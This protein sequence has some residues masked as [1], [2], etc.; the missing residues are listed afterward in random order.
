[1]LGSDDSYIRAILSRACAPVEEGGLGYRAAVIIFRGCA[2]SYTYVFGFSSLISNLYIGSGVPLTSQLM[3]SAGHTND[4]RQ[5]LMYITHRYPKAVLLGLGFSLGA[6]VLT[7]YLGE[8][9]A[10]SRIS[11]ACVLACVCLLT[12]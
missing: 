11:S 9:G 2:F 3:Y 5:A 4:T 6:N 12:N 8:E 10:Q 1:V 7:R